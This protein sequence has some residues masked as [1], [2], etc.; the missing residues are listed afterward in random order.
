MPVLEH[1]ARWEKQCGPSILQL[2][3]ALTAAYFANREQEAQEVYGKMLNMNCSGMQ[4]EE[5]LSAVY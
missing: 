2:E 1:C 4:R 5:V 3:G